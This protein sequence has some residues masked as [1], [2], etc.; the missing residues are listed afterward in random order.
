MN[1]RLRQLRKALKI[2]QE[3]FAKKIGIKRNTLAN[4]EIGRN[5]PIDAVIFSICREFC[6]NEE[7]L[8]TGE[9]SMFFEMDREDELAQWAGTLARPDNDN[10]FM[11][12]FVHMLSKLDTD[13]WKLLEKM[14]LM[15]SEDNKKD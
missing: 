11:K 3:E 12:R 9:G 8:R 7:W 2:T 13:D 14:A 10:D 6:V 1:E 5:E 4:Y 15:M